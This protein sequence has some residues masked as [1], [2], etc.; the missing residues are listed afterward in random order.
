MY[1]DGS[2]ST[3]VTV[4]IIFNLNEIDVNWSETT[5]PNDNIENTTDS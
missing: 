4:N 2:N 5:A 1:I 3:I